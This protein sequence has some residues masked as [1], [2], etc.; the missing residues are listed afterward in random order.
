MTARVSTI[1]IV[2]LALVGA[3]AVPVH[4]AGVSGSK[5][6]LRAAGG[7]VAIGTGLVQVCVTCHTPHQATA[8]AAQTPLWNHSA[9][10]FVGNYGVY[11]SSTMQASPT[12]WGAG[13]IGSQN[14]SQLCMGCH[15]GTVSVLSMYKQP[16]L[17]GTPT[18]AAIAGFTA[19]A[20]NN[21][22]AAFVGTSL[23]D[24]HPVNF[25]YD[26][27]LATSDGGLTSP[28]SATCVGAA[29][30]CQ[31]PLFPSGGGLTATVQCASCHDP[32]DSANQ[33]FLRVSNAASALCLTCH[34]K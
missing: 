11:T 2:A 6:D 10:T 31:V 32:H 30:P 9:S 23:T 24:D 8:A 17:G 18:A 28:A 22:N 27:A 15:D 20:M 1:P 21:T 5:H 13:V 16:N 3:L 25:T 7:G 33:P 26:A 34:I 19:G 12:N 29:A 14:T 4:A